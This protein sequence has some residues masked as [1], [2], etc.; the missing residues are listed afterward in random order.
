MDQ[1]GANEKADVETVALLRRWHDGDGQALE[2]LL[3]RD[4]PWIEEHVRRRLGPLLRRDNETQDIVQDTLV[5]VLRY[6]PRFLLQNHGH[7]RALLAK[8][9]EN[10]LRMEH[11]RMTAKKRDVRRVRPLPSALSAI[12]LDP[13][14][15]VPTRPEVAAERSEM[16]SWMRLALEFLGPDDRQVILLK[17]WDGLT[18]AEIGKRLGVAEDAARMRFNRALPKLAKKVEALQGGE[19]GS[20]L[21]GGGA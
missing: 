18:F 15:G 7:F 10:E 16:Q 5:E 2:A 17:E 20:L 8:I 12:S 4:L 13:A 9:V 21:E 6:G 3:E 14:L 1:P 11:E 19:I